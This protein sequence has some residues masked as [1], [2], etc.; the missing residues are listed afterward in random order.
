MRIGGISST[1]GFTSI[2]KEVIM[3]YRRRRRRF[4]RSRIRRRSR[5]RRTRPLRIGLRM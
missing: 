5:S 3:R 2:R 4:G 1:V